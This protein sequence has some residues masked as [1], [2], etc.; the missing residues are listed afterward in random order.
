[1][2]HIRMEAAC[3]AVVVF[4]MAL[5]FFTKRK[6]SYVNS[7]F[8]V[9]LLSA[10]LEIAAE[11]VM[12]YIL[13]HREQ[14]PDIFLA[15]STEIYALFL[16]LTLFM[17]LIYIKAMIN[18]E[19][20]SLE[21][22]GMI[23][24]VL[25]VLLLGVIAIVI[26][27]ASEW[28]RNLFELGRWILLKYLPYIL[29]VINIM[30]MIVRKWKYIN[31]KR[32][33]ILF[34]FLGIQV[35]LF[36]GHAIIH[37]G[38]FAGA[39]IMLIVLALYMTL[40]NPDV[41]LI[42]QLKR[43]K[44]KADEANKAKTSFIA[45]V[46]HEI[47]TPINA[48][49]GMDEMILR[50]GNEE[51]IKQYALDI[52]SAAQTLYSIINDILDLS[53]METGKMELVPVKYS[54]RSLLNDAANMIL[55][56]AEAKNLEFRVEADET[57]PS[58]LYGDDVRIRQVLTN[59]LSNAVKYTREGSVILLVRGTWTGE[60]DIKLYFEVKDTGIGMKEEDLERLFSE[61]ERIE[62]ARNRNIE[63]TGLGMSITI[64]LLELMGSSL[65]VQSR[66]GEGTTF[67]FE[68]I[69]KI[70]DA[71]PMGVL[72]KKTG[73]RMED[74]SYQT[75]FTAPKA[76]ILIVDDNAMNRK[77]FRALL[78]KTRVQIDEAES[79]P[80]CLNLIRQ[81]KYDMIFLD[82]MMPDMDGVETFRKMKEATDNLSADAPIIMLTANAVSGAREQYMEVGFDDFLA[83]PVEPAKLER[84]LSYYLFRNGRSE[85]WYK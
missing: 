40:E 38:N 48:V 18:E 24:N 81:E 19:L 29:F 72:K 75:S 60:S 9:L 55:L 21:R 36:A 73:E 84:M 59:I 27:V 46:S 85:S 50:E 74:Y 32:R 2:I 62:S 44:E 30:G 26:V 28:G 14:I 68:L 13:H 16:V 49:L 39:D 71:S 20:P 11:G 10:F 52:K 8:S 35:I 47:R 33:Q 58:E 15:V 3:L 5:F 6:N 57:I 37:G 77:V 66:Y 4:V 42:E 83:K 51:Q 64:Q 80:A 69:Q 65:H 34:D 17:I 25:G 78:A 67:S 63:G 76:H 82:H 61:Y 45:N 43:E 53:K 1:M 70:V 23:P 56:K 54:T 7:C 79:G 22:I 12:E 41:H 31:P